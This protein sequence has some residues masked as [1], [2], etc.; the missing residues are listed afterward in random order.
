M[1]IALLTERNPRDAHPLTLWLGVAALNRHP[2]G[3][4]RQCR[5]V[6]LPRGQTAERVNDFLA[7]QFQGIF[8]SHSF[9]HSCECG[10]A[11]QRGRTAVCEEAHGLDAAILNSQTE[12]QTIT[13]DRICFFSDGVCVG[14]FARVARMREVI[15][16]DF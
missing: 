4:D 9:Q 11:G 15:F 8:D 3:L 6:L 16:E 2:Q 1:N 12:T 7:G 10:A 5:R 14:E 13:A